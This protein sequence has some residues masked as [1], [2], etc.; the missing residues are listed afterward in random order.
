MSDKPS[1][2][3]PDTND[4]QES[5]SLFTTL[6]QMTG[7]VSLRAGLTAALAMIML[8]PLGMVSSVVS[9]RGYRYQGV[10]NEI[11]ST[12]GN[13]QTIAGPVL[14][15]PFTQQVTVTQTIKGK[16]GKASEH[17][18]TIEKQRQAHF[19]PADLQLRTS[20]AEEFRTRSIFKSIVFQA[21]V[22]V[23]AS[24]DLPAFDTLAENITGIHWNK[25]FISVGISDTRAINSVED[26]TWNG[27][28]ANLSPGTQ[29]KSLPSGF[30]AKLP[31]SNSAKIK[32]G[33]KVRLDKPGVHQLSLRLSVKGSGG[34][35]FTSHGE[36]T[37][38][39]VESSWPHP[40]FQGA[41]L[42]TERTITDEGFHASWDISHLARNYPQHWVDRQPD[43]FELTA[44]V[45]MFEPNSLYSR[46]TKA[47]KY[48]ILFIGLT[49]LT[50]FIFELSIGK[51]IQFIQF[52]LIG[53]SLS[54]FY[55]VLLSLSEH[56]EFY[57]A[58]AA[59]TFTCTTMISV[60][61]GSVLHSV[62][63]GLFV[64]VKLFGLYAL[65]YSLVKM[66]D[67]ALLMGTVVLLLVVCVLMVLTRNQS[68]LLASS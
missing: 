49:F 22:D 15:V 3:A 7:S 50:L 64:A 44:G 63:R 54:L 35:Y 52:G 62:L 25:A 29:L 37:R 38:V 20:L 6:N 68:S 24:F 13:E 66:E 27:Q 36:R 14:T 16:D 8:I 11:A 33:E 2:D 57:K 18:K 45:R 47:T 67:F 46:I 42:P 43:L 12:W 41:T 26:F 23:D 5:S 58:Y 60:Y 51:R 30:H 21:N 4:P 39:S 56:I 59:A 31:R 10:I 19:L 48:G 40:S 32:A 61:T 53:V 55:L 65:L 9:E 34:F 17:K 1:S 28:Q